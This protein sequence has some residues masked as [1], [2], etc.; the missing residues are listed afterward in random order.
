MNEN[1]TPAAAAT[2]TSEKEKI[3]ER[4]I[5][6]HI[7]YS[8]M[9]ARCQVVEIT[10]QE[11]DMLQYKA[12]RYDMLKDIAVKSTFVTDTESII[13]G[14]DKYGGISYGKE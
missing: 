2:A 4:G 13:F 5:T 6:P 3:T 8:T 1:K 7:D 11:Y 12:T 9:P 14:I 10:R